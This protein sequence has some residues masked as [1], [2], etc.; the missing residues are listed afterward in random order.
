MLTKALEIQ[1]LAIVDAEESGLEPI[2]RNVIKSDFYK[3]V[4]KEITRAYTKMWHPIKAKR[5]CLSAKV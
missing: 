4:M 1:L 5:E 2:A 3:M